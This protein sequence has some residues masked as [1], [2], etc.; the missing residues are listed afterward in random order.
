[1]PSFVRAGVML[2]RL[3]NSLDE[4]RLAQEDALE[5]GWDWLRANMSEGKDVTASEVVAFVRDL[6]PGADLAFIREGIRRRLMECAL[7][8]STSP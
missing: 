4:E 6:S 1:M 7:S 2:Q 8:P 3:N 5:A